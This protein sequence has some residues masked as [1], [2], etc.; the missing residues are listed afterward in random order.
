M[1][2]IHLSKIDKIIRL[3]FLSK[4]LTIR[5]FKYFVIMYYFTNY[6]YI[7]PN[8]VGIIFRSV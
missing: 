1:L 2:P 7:Y 3:S 8:T 5:L 6:I 4:L